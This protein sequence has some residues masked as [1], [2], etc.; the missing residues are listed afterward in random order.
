MLRR[1]ILLVPLAL[2]V[3]GAAPP[4]RDPLDAAARDYV[5]L[6]LAIGEKE[7]GYIDAY[8][9]PEALKAEGKALVARSGLPAL[10]R[11]AGQLR[12]RVERLGARSSAEN[13][14]RA[15]YVAAQLIA[16]VTR[17]R[18]LRGEKLS[19]DDEALGQFAVRPKLKPLSSFDRV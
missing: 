15:R 16:A 9:G 5:R 14:R 4:V 18:M 7:D 6:Q 19:F 2:A 11:E 17:L 3:I 10:Q 8:Y 12:A 13:A 1:L